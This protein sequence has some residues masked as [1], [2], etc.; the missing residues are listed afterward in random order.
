MTNT[1]WGW[2][3]RIKLRHLRTALAVNDCGGVTGASR[4][5]FISQAAVSKTISEIEGAL[6]T[7][8]FTRN[9]RSLVPTDAGRRFLLSARKIANEVQNLDEEISHLVTGG[10]GILRI[11]MQAIS[12]HDRLVKV[13]GE[14]RQRYPETVIQFRDGVLPDLLAALRSGSLDLVLGRLLPSLLTPDLEGVPVT[15]SDPSIIVASVNHPALAGQKPDWPALLEHFWCLPLRGTPLRIHFDEFLEQKLLPP[16][17]RSIETNSI[18]L[19]RK[20]MAEFP[21]ITPSPRGFALEWERQGEVELTD[22]M[23]AS[24]PNPIGIIW[25]RNTQLPTPARVFH[26]IFAS[27]E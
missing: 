26:K 21:L 25:N 17:V 22:L 18:P 6:R 9:G 8:I 1:R 23:I 27:D 19:L 11:G 15:A 7:D 20:F 13:V 16:P 14:M 3:D 2:D 24:Q 10:A 12:V 5:L 4:Q